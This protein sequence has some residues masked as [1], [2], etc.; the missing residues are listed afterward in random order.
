[1][2]QR[3]PI[4][5]LRSR[6][7]RNPIRSP[8]SRLRRD[9]L[10]GLKGHPIVEHAGDDQAHSPDGDGP[11]DFSIFAA[12]RRHRDAERQESRTGG[13]GRLVEIEGRGKRQRWHQHVEASG[14]DEGRPD[15]A[16]H[17][18]RC[19]RGQGQQRER[20]EGADLVKQPRLLGTF[21]SGL[22]RDVGRPPR[23]AKNSIVVGNPP[24]RGLLAQVPGSAS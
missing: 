7:L 9:A 8:R 19:D 2:L 21:T 4:V 15:T 17:E 18:E 20:R 16:R 23:P 1:M 6:R 22:V 14:H 13:A 11:A 10:N 5:M 24:C 3:T 12:D